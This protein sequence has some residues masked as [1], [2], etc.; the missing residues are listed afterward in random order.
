MF[1]YN[2]KSEYFEENYEN[3]FDDDIPAYNNDFSYGDDFKKEFEEKPF[4]SYSRENTNPT[5]KENK[6]NLNGLTL[7]LMSTAE[8]PNLDKDDLMIYEIIPN[9]EINKENEKSNDDTN[10]INI[11]E[12]DDQNYIVENADNNVN[13]EN[14]ENDDDDNANNNNNNKKPSSTT[15]GQKKKHD[16][17]AD[18]NVIKKCKNILI[19]CLFSFI[20]EKIRR[21]YNNNIGKGIF[22]KQ[23]KKL[24]KTKLAST[25]VKDNKELLHKTLEDIFSDIS[26]KIDSCLKDFNKNLIKLLKDEKDYNKKKYFQKLFNLTF[27][28]CL[29]HFNGK[30]CHEELCG[31][32]N[33]KKKIEKFSQDEDYIKVLEYY[34]VNFDSIICSKKSRKQRH[35]K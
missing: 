34:F 21:L 24:D 13:D 18:D 20:N 30:V 25:T 5:D 10:K 17:Y 29:N 9:K 15:T 16:K 3:R 19:D 31:M 12:N 14:N 7:P 2:D 4:E 27:L 22:T 11:I 6:N 23:F 35:K 32:T 28:Q 33:M 1:V 26:G 8:T